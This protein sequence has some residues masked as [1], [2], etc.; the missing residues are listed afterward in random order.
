M[1]ECHC[2]GVKHGIEDRVEEL[3][4]IISYLEKRAYSLEEKLKVIKLNEDLEKQPEAGIGIAQA[5][6][7]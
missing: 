7:N 4:A 1:S 3:E 6:L 5:I 2:C